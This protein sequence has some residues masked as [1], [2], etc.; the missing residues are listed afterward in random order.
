MY[1]INNIYGHG[2]LKAPPYKHFNH[3]IDTEPFLFVP[4]YGRIRQIVTDKLITSSILFL[5]TNG[6]SSLNRPIVDTF[7]NLQLLRAQLKLF[8]FPVRVAY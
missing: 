5:K 2:F 3:N 7:L 1:R 8:S 4:F 6:A